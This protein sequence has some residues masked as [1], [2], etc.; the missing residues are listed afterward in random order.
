VSDRPSPVDLSMLLAQAA[1]DAAQ[2]R[3]D[4]ALA[5]YSDV[6]AVAPRNA[7]VHYNV[8]ALNTMRGELDAAH[9]AFAEAA[10]IRPDWILPQLA[11]GHLHFRA[12]RFADAEA[13]FDRATRQ[14][15]GSLDAWFNL[16]AARDR[17]RR[18]PDALPALR[19]ARA[20]AP[21]NEDVWYALRNHLLLFGRGDE[22][23]D[24]FLKFEAGAPPS[25]RI[26][27]AGLG[28]ARAAPDARLE[29]KYLPLALDWPYRPSDLDQLETVLTQLPYFDVTREQLFALYREYDEA[30]QSTRSGVADLTRRRT[31]REGP[32][33]I[34]Y[35]SA[36]F[37]THIMGDLIYEVIR[38]HDRN[39]FAIHAY[40]L[41]VREIEDATTDAFR[42]IC[43]RF[44]RVDDLDDYS[45][46]QAIAADEIDV[47]VDLMAHSSSSRPRVLLY[48]P[49]PVI[50]THLGSHGAIGLSQVD[51]K[52]TDRHADRDD[53]ARYQVERPLALDTCV[54]PVR[55]VAPA[56]VVMA[57]ADHGI[58]DDAVVFGAFVGLNKLSPRCVAL[59]RRVLDMVPRGVIAFSPGAKI[60]DREPYLRRLAGLGFDPARAVF[61]PRSRDLALDRARYRMIDVVLDTIPYTGGDTS[62]AALDMGV[63]VVTRIGDRQAERMTASLLMHLGVTATIAQSDDDYVAVAARLGND[64]DF[65]RAIAKEIATRLEPS[66]IADFD[67]YTASLEAAYER[68]Y[69]TS[70]A[71]SG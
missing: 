59:W 41:A 24:D 31:R 69:A 56:D 54:L 20:I 51:Y 14:D 42:A 5:R 9:A 1:S 8:G 2:G 10:A 67:R 3:I 71:K 4:A 45:I 33:R 30:A 68:A 11:L 55:R 64:V 21:Q 23:F 37:R 36:D 6:L 53:A 28:S 17:L 70:V 44:T 16:A 61:L 25:A 39:R 12:Q 22:A 49:A 47:L 13:A 19:R 40:S 48:K 43:A 57:R 58:A 26:V 60:V 27:A 65:R 50:V 38:R 29:Q 52:L 63:P 15:S 62:A 46:A 34:G 35:L 7:E 32:L 18:W 66:G